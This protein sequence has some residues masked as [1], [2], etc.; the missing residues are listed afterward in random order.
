MFLKHRAVIRRRQV[1]GAS[2]TARSPWFCQPLTLAMPMPRSGSVASQELRLERCGDGG[3]QDGMCAGFLS[4][5]L[6][7]YCPLKLHLQSTYSNIKLLIISRQQ[8]QEI[9]ETPELLVR[10]EPSARLGIPGQGGQPA[11]ATVLET[12][13][14]CPRSSLPDAR[15]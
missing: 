9:N 15:Y 10:A 5:W 12:G 7:I 3:R 13:S 14:R 1:P 11:G 4:P 8:P 6:V 2:P